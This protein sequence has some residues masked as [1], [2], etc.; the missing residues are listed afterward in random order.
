MIRVGHVRLYREEI[1][2]D[3]I[4]FQKPFTSAEAWQWLKAEAR[5]EKTKIVVQRR[6]GKKMID[7]ELGFGD[8]AHSQRI[9]AKEWGWDRG[10]VRR[11]L[12]NL[13]KS[14]R[15]AVESPDP[16]SG[17][18]THHQTTRISICNFD[19]Y[20]GDRPTIRPS[21]APPNDPSI[22]KSFKNKETTYMSDADFDNWWQS[23]FLPTYRKGRTAGKKRARTVLKNLVQSAEQLKEVEAAIKH[24]L[25]TKDNS[26]DQYVLLA[27]TFF[28]NIEDH[29]DIYRMA[30]KREYDPD[31]PDYLRDL[32][33]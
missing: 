25:K 4:G 2:D 20:S 9:L 10:K 27:S 3:L 22:K 30:G 18:A 7:I 11:F 13:E 31:I 28:N 12:D 19:D 15:I 5:W 24:Y 23:F 1:N 21:N 8:L 17:P 16:Q 29:L 32:V 26:E 6:S 33:V 14:G